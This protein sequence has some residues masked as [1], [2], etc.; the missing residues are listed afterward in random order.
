MY[1]KK[2]Q[3]YKL[4]Y[5]KSIVGGGKYENDSE[6]T[7]FVPWDGYVFNKT[8]APVDTQT[9]QCQKFDVILTFIRTDETNLASVEGTER[10]EIYTITINEKKYSDNG[11]Y[12]ALSE[13]INDAELNICI[14]DPIGEK[15][16]ALK[17][18]PILTLKGRAKQYTVGIDLTED[19]L[20][21][22]NYYKK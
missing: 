15:Y 4:K 6:H 21:R 20:T 9:D 11:T 3:K 10:N 5:L 12:S 14:S 2:Y 13:K 17:R 19:E 8:N 16:P 18:T 7:L 1:H 22:I